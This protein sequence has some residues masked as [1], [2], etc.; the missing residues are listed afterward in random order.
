MG[1][2][3]SGH[4]RARGGGWT[5]LWL[6]PLLSIA[7]V[8]ALGVAPTAGATAPADVAF[9]E[10]R[11]TAG[12][13]EGI[14]F[15]QPV[16]LTDAPARVEI[17]VSA[18]DSLG[19]AV[20][21]VLAPG[22]GATTLRYALGPADA[23]VLPNTTLTARWRITAPDGSV[24]LGPSATVTYADDRFDWQT[25]AGDLVR[26]HWYEGD[27]AF[28]RRAREIGEAGVAEAEDLLGVTEAAPVDFFIYADE[29]AFYDA[30]GP[31]TRENVGGQANAGIR[32]LFAL[33]SPGEIGDAWVRA[34]VPHELTHLVFDTAVRNP[35][36]YPPRWL[37]EGVAVYM[38]EGYGGSDRREVEEAAGDGS[39]M[40][41][42][43][44]GGQ[45]PTSFERFSLAYAESVSAVDFLVAEHGRDALARLITSYGAGVTDD[46]AFEA[47]IGMDAQAFDAAWRAALEAGDPVRHGP[48]PAP[49]GPVPADWERPPD[50]AGSDAPD[51][52][53]PSGRE[54]DAPAAPRPDDG[55]PSS[56]GVVAAGAFAV[57]GAALAVG[58]M[59]WLRRRDRRAGPS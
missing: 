6:G 32:T 58:A 39:L 10:P 25:D 55:E 33:I 46:E 47:A 22:S 41:L 27:A 24:D 59:V 37:N 52:P 30:L 45:F 4:G 1:R 19:P 49:G 13:G 56:I 54:T 15:E 26:V 53:R 5:R 48:Q 36:Q 7:V 23:H 21:E 29:D 43:A 28:G 34:V 8:L 12:F 18:P 31:G 44:L 40:P 17:L 3:V 14:T 20:T 51:A 42:A 16:T 50:A 35:Y 38:S 11:A 2:I 9:G 57:G